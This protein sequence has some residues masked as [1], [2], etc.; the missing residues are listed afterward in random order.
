MSNQ[1]K[2]ADMMPGNDGLPIIG[3]LVDAISKQELYY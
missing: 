1:L 2:S 3:D